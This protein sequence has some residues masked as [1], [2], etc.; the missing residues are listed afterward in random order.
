M[1]RNGED[2]RDNRL[3]RTRL[4]QY[5]ALMRSGRVLSVNHGIEEK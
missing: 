3:W 4:G 1:L 2:P 5:D